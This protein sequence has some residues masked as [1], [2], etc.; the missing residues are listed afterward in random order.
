VKPY[1]EALITLIISLAV[2][3]AVAWAGAQGGALAFDLPVLAL[4]AAV[5]FV[6]NW[7]VFVPAFLAHTERFYDLTG[8]LT[9]LSVVGFALALSPP[10]PRGWLLAGLIAVWAV[11]LGTFL[12]RRV[13]QD[14]GDGR[15]D[16]MKH[17]APRFFVAWTLQGL[18]VFLTA[19]AALTAITAPDDGLGIVDAVGA[20]IWL[21][22]FTVEVVADRQK[23]AFKRDP[24]NAGRFITTGLWGWSRHPNY[25]G[26]ILLWVGAAVLA[27]SALDG[28]RYASLISPVF[29]FVLLRYISGVPLLAA[30]ND[31]RWGDEPEYQAYK[32]S[33]PV[34]IP[35]PPR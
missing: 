34:L 33:T 17:S 21:A 5:A 23:R 12:F 28:W 19:S 24:A 22:G 16:E 32:A 7:V 20:L 11:R 8:T 14:G 9:Y 2:A 4:C 26:E 6:V 3:G 30:R 10:S 1:V 35:R 27:S 29:V 31:A 18:W 13:H 15:F 25:F